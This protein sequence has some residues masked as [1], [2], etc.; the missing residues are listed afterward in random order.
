MQQTLLA[1]S[2]PARTCRGQLRRFGFNEIHRPYQTLQTA[3]WHSGPRENMH[4]D[5][6]WYTCTTIPRPSPSLGSPVWN[7]SYLH[8]WPPIAQFRISLMALLGGGRGGGGGGGGGSPCVLAPP[9]LAP[10]EQTLWDRSTCEGGMCRMHENVYC[11]LGKSF[12]VKV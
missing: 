5:G 6:V 12:I 4:A 11:M 9:S 8:L 2:G 10:E 1:P 7:L 3:A